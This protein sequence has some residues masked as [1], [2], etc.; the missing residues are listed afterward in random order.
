MI[1][2]NLIN[3]ILVNVKFNESKNLVTLINK[4]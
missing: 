3:K 1:A 2:I 4:I